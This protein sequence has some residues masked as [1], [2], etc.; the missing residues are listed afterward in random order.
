[1]KLSART[2]RLAAAEEIP[3]PLLFVHIPKTAGTSLTAYLERQYPADTVL[4]H[5]ENRVFQ[6]SPEENRRLG[7]FRLLSAHLEFETLERLVDVERHLKITVFRE[8]QRQLASHLAWIEGLGAPG[9]RAELA[10]MPEYIRS[11]V[12]RIGRLGHAGF[13]DALTPPEARLLDNCQTRYL[14]P[15]AT[16]DV[17][18]SLLPGALERLERFSL[19][20]TTERLD[21]FLLLL[22]QRMGW[23]P[24]EAA[25]R[26]NAGSRERLE[27][28]AP[29]GELEKPFERLTRLDR[30]VYAAAAARFERDFGEAPLHRDSP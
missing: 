19:V 22:A 7:D 25:P 4:L 1:M 21:D 8:P 20:G 26:L 30:A 17:D 6:G 15:Q 12:E 10:Q 11:A 3:H 27:G 9:K 16:V 5:A 29:A 14:L 24:P 13:L 2:I 18:E 23:E 28:L